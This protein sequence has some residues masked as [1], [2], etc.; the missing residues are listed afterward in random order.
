MPNLLAHDQ[1]A[2]SNCAIRAAQSRMPEAWDGL[3]GAWSPSVGHQGMGLFPL[4]AG[5]RAPFTNLNTGDYVYDQPGLVLDHTTGA[6]EYADTNLTMASMVQ[7]TSLVVWRRKAAG[8]G[9]YVASSN[10]TAANV[11]QLASAHTDGNVY[12][13]PTIVGFGWYASNDALWHVTVSRFDGTQAT[14]STRMRAW[15]DGA[16]Q[17]LSFSGTVEASTSATPGTIL[18]GYRPSSTLQSNGRTGT[19]MVW[20]RLLPTSLI[21]ELTWRHMDV[22]RKRIRAAARTAR[23]W[24][25]RPRHSQIIGGGVL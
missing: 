24:L 7:Y 12:V 4:G 23:P 17:S 2:L 14:N 25:Y 22:F 11:V 3:L 18:I 20:N 10:G 19:V 15:H 6:A 1:P 5:Q 16:E 21:S 13:N 9:V 8:S